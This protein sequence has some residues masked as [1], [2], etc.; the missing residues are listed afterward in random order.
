MAGRNPVFKAVRTDMLSP[1]IHN[2]TV[3]PGCMTGTGR[4]RRKA[5]YDQKEDFG[6]LSP[7]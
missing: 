7:V 2:L 3:I 1:D 6:I 4:G 5:A